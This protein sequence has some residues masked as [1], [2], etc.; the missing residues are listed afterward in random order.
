NFAERKGIVFEE[1]EIDEG[2]E[3]LVIN[4]RTVFEENKVVVLEDSEEDN[5]VQ[6]ISTAITNNSDLAMMNKSDNP[7]IETSQQE[8]IEA[9][10]NDK[11]DDFIKFALPLLAY[12]D[13]I[14]EEEKS[15]NINFIKK[16]GTYINKNEKGSWSEY[17]C[18]LY[19]ESKKVSCD[20]TLR[21]HY[22][23]TNFSEV[24]VIHYWYKHNEHVPGSHADVKYL[25][26]SEEII[27]K[28]KKFA[29]QGLSLSAIR[30]LMKKPTE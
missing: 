15:K 10:P 22:N 11:K 30:W 25:R 20:Y 28:I 24:V 21:V 3:V 19:A 27:T 29:W 8:V 2:K 23:L 5:E 1:I 12:H 16:H 9:E 14:K 7:V 4:E 18:C 26:K 13:W 6:V 17:Y